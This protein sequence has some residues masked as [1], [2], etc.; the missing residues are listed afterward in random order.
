MP[1]SLG[2]VFIA[3]QKAPF[4]R[5]PCML[6]TLARMGGFERPC[7]QGALPATAS[8]SIASLPTAATAPAG[9]GYGAMALD[10]PEL[11]LFSVFYSKIGAC[12]NPNFRDAGMAAAL[13]DKWI[14]DY[15]TDQKM[16][17]PNSAIVIGQSAGG[18]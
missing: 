10:I 9:P 3:H 4:M 8:S 2:N 14:I 7:A 6:F 13:L 18:W 16:A 15:M 1:N 11:G 5:D 12:E 17:V